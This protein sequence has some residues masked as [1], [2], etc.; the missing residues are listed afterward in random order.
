[1]RFN[2]LPCPLWLCQLPLLQ[3]PFHSYTY[4]SFLDYLGKFYNYLVAGSLVL[5]LREQNYLSIDYLLNTN[6]RTH[7]LIAQLPRLSSYLS[8]D[9]VDLNGE[10]QKESI[11]QQ[12]YRQGSL[13][14]RAQR[15]PSGSIPCYKISQRIRSARFRMKPRKEQRVTSLT[16]QCIKSSSS[17]LAMKYQKHQAFSSSYQQLRSYQRR[18]QAQL[19]SCRIRGAVARVSTNKIGN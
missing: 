13:I 9:R 8:S 1:M 4:L 7:F 5:L 2:P 12:T 15:E 3:H 10:F 16:F 18:N 6:T 17:F 19:R 14:R 11:D